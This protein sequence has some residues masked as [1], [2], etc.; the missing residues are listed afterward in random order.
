MESFR[1]SV[2]MVPPTLIRYMLSMT[3]AAAYDQQDPER[4][5]LDVVCVYV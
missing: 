5:C 3:S 2:C 4:V 1:V